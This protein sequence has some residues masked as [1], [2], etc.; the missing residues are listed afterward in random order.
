MDFVYKG[1]P[2]KKLEGQKPFMKLK[3]FGTHISSEALQKLEGD[4]VQNNYDL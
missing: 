3:N 2:V 4:A 1:M